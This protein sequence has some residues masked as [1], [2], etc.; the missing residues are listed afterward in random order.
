[1]KKPRRDLNVTSV[2][3]RLNIVRRTKDFKAF[4]VTALNDSREALNE[5]AKRTDELAQRDIEQAQRDTEQAQRHTE[6]AQ[7][8]EVLVTRYNTLLLQH[9]SLVRSFLRKFPPQSTLLAVRKGHRVTLLPVD[10]ALGEE[11]AGF[12]PTR[13][14]LLDWSAATDIRWDVAYRRGSFYE[15]DSRD[16]WPTGIAD[17]L[18]LLIQNEGADGETAIWRHMVTSDA[19]ASRPSRLPR[20]FKPEQA[21][22]DVRRHRLMIALGARDSALLP[23]LHALEA[24]GERAPFF[25]P[26]AEDPVP[27]V[28]SNAPLKA[29][30]RK[31]SVLFVNPAYYNFKYLAAA[32]RDR[33]WDAISMAIIDPAS[34]NAKHYHGHDWNF[35]VADASAQLMELREKFKEIIGRFDM[36]HFAGVGVMSFFPYNYDTSI[37]HD[38]VPW[39]VIEMKRRGALIGY[40]TTGCHD[41]VTQS[42]F[43]GWS[44]TSC[45]VCG[46]R[47]RP[48]ICSNHRMASWG[49]KV[50][51]L[52]D[53][54]CIETDPPLDFRDTPSTFREPL[55]MA[56]DP[57]FWQPELARG[58][59]VPEE[60]KEPRQEGEILIY[61]S[62]GNYDVR[63]KNG[64]NMKG[65]GAVLKAVER[66]KNE[67]LPVRLLFRKNVPSVDNRWMLAQADIVVDQLN[68]GRYGATA[69]EGLMLGRPV[70]GRL[71]KLEP[72]GIPPVRAIAECPIVDADEETVYSAL[73]RLVDDPQERARV[74]AESRA[75][76]LRWWSKDVLAERYERVYD[77]LRAYGRPPATLDA[78]V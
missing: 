62:V 57:T 17:S 21:N 48:E 29:E 1:M 76:A 64:V 4:V 32:L 49:W 53:L 41:L 45:P 5:L 23:H 33:G 16:D 37:D 39:D 19:A 24:E 54:I 22:A 47:D 51:Q 40:S 31:R 60:W 52:A 61:H 10:P 72:G 65:T 38:R 44:P 27:R 34:D 63:T 36:F 78:R 20:G 8:N 67:G 9:E 2:L 74:G 59:P 18:R 58:T 26:F 56:I 70:V 30:A 13:A 68:Y 12:S 75:Y 35:F 11:F 55:T 69:R 50:R 71:N 43:E 28:L 14:E 73:K 66:L 42:S 15:P 25:P 3:G 7:R 77:H 6:L 46:W